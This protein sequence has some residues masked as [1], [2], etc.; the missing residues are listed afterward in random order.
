M[1][2]PLRA[3]KASCARGLIAGAAVTFVLIALG[4]QQTGAGRPPAGTGTSPAHTSAHATQH[5]SAHTTA[6]GPAT[7]SP[8]RSPSGAPPRTIPSVRDFTPASGPGWRPGS[9]SR[10]VVDLQGPLADEARLIAAELGLRTASG[11]ARS[12]DLSLAL[13]PKQSG[14]K[15]A[16]TL[17]VDKGRARITGP[18]QAGVFYGTRTVKQA[19][20]SGGRLPEGVIHD[21]PARAQRGLNLDIARKF[22]TAEWIQARMRQ[23]ADL[24][25]NQLALHFSDDQGFRIQSS[26]HP[27]IV[28]A[29]H[30][31][32]T[33][34]RQIV[35]LGQ[36]LH[37]TVIP[38]ID[39]PGH[40]GAVIRAHPQ[41]Q[42]RNA[43]GTTFQGAV[44][45]SNPASARIVDQLM[46]EYAPLFP[47]R[48]WHLGADEYL[49][50]TVK[51]PQASFPKLAAAAKE[52]YGPSARVQD[53]A[54]GW[55][56]DRARLA[57]QLGKR[58]KAWN[59]G[60]FAGGVVKPDKNIEVEYWTGRLKETARQP[61]E[62]LKEGRKVVNLN[63]AYLYYVLGEPGGFTYPTGERIYDEWSPAILRGS[64]PIADKSLTGPDRVLGAR[65]A[66]WGD[67]PEAQTTTQVAQ[68]IRLPLAA[69]AQR[70]WDPG[71]PPLSWSDFTRLAERLGV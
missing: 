65:F 7:T 22:F 38:E 44:D 13:A 28:S 35:A 43:G 57:R 41:L 4:C 70:V 25:L 67:H 12:G 27:E 8:A 63:D 51:D 5:T 50:L 15:E 31:T 55:L 17:T 45:I 20:R 60:F 10:V 56:N 47:G 16:Y 36:R 33:Q 42:L 3:T 18:G 46:R 11:T 69:L 9:G 30:L 59:D 64:T 14:G 2:L 29:Q 68:G 23:M 37:I 26:T 1:G 6:T 40:L 53:L 71:K 32:K 61:L 34:V 58:P 21:R 39:S 66:V 54:T 62:Y 48:W 24:K 52:R 19:L 49:A